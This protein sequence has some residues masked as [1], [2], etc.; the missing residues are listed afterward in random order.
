MSNFDSTYPLEVYRHVSDHGVQ[1]VDGHMED[2]EFVGCTT[3]PPFT[4]QLAESIAATRPHWARFEDTDIGPETRT[5]DHGH[6]YI[7]WARAFG[8][9]V[10]VEQEMAYEWTGDLVG[11]MEFPHVMVWA[12]SQF[13][14]ELASASDVRALAESLAS[15]AALM[16]DLEAVSH[17][18]LSA[19]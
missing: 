5:D 6:I 13:E 14:T 1:L 10:V 18:D 3:L 19:E 17:R 15:A 11:T 12:D 7:S 16:D 4:R 2:G 9:R 8:E